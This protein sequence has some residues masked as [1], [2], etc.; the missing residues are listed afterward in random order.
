MN[1]YVLKRKWLRSTLA[2][3][4]KQEGG[5]R[6][7]PVSRHEVQSYFNEMFR[8]K[9]LRHSLASSPQ[10]ENTTEAV[11]AHIWE[12]A[13]YGGTATKRGHIASAVYKVFRQEL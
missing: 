5:E 7:I 8:S 3:L 9:A 11:F 1:K 10:S 6:N 4:K 2:E 13:G 12:D